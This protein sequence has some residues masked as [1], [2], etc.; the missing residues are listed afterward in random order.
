VGVD[1]ISSTIV[2]LRHRR[3]EASSG[4]ARRPSAH[5]TRRSEI[6]TNERWQSAEDAFRL[7]GGEEQR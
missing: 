3:G 6:N 7:S 5:P 1:P 4:H 2:V